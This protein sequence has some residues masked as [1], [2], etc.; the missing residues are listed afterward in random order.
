MDSRAGA[1]AATPMA[2][3]AVT[4]RWFDIN[5]SIDSADLALPDCGAADVNG[6]LP[7]PAAWP[8]SVVAAYGEEIRSGPAKFRHQCFGPTG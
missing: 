3:K 1:V 4:V 6:L 2:S 7:Y 8:G 5:V